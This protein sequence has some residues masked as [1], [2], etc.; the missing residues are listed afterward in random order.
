V[1]GFVIF[2]VLAAAGLGWLW[3]FYREGVSSRIVVKLNADGLTV[4]DLFGRTIPWSEVT[5]VVGTRWGIHVTVRGEGR[6]KPTTPRRMSGARCVGPALPSFL[7]VWPSELVAS[8]QA[9][10]AYFGNGS[11][12]G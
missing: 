4:P 1:V 11:Q 9:H 2:A 6:F 5:D 12:S 8:I 10:R 3:R 7:D